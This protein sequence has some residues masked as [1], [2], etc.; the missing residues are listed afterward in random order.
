MSFK[1]AG[2]RVWGLVLYLRLLAGEAL[3][4]IVSHLESWDTDLLINKYSI[5][6]FKKTK[7]AMAGPGKMA[8]I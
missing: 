2:G 3:I 7:R 4:I 1:G 8:G 6:D 5:S